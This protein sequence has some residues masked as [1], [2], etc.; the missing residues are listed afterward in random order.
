MLCY[1]LDDVTFWFM[2]LRTSR[3]WS[4]NVIL[5]KIAYLRN[6]WASFTAFV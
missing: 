1:L 4:I 3:W 6:C 5:S 2:L